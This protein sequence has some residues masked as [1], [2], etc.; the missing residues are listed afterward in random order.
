VTGSILLT[1]NFLK[2]RRQTLDHGEYQP[3]YAKISGY[4]CEDNKNESV[5]EN[6]EDK[7]N[8]VQ[9]DDTQTLSKEEI[10]DKVN[11]ILDNKGDE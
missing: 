11:D 4:K 5:V 1:I 2:V 7:E 9:E 6:A 10:T 8:D 3:T